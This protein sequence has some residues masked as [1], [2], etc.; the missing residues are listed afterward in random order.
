M[1]PWAKRVVLSVFAQVG[2][3]LGLG[4]SDAQADPYGV[5]PED[6]GA[7]RRTE[8]LVIEEGQRGF[9]VI[10]R[11]TLESQAARFVWLQPI[12]GALEA[13]DEA[14]DVFDVLAQALV[15]APEFSEELRRRPFGPSI[16]NYLTRRFRPD[17][18]RAE[19]LVAP[20]AR[21][22]EIDALAYFTGSAKTS[23]I[24]RRVSLPR[25]LED[26]L[27]IHNVSISQDERRF[28]G[29]YLNSGWSILGAAM[30]DRAPSPEGVAR[31]GPV[32]L[33]FSGGDRSLPLV[34]R[35]AP[36]A[37]ELVVYALADGPRVPAELPSRPPSRPFRPKEA[38]AG[39]ML[40]PH[41]DRLDQSPE[42]S[43]ALAE[44]FGNELLQD[45]YLT[46]LY[47][48]PGSARLGRLTLHSPEKVAVQ[49]QLPTSSQRGTPGDFF[50]CLLLG[51]TPLFLT[52]EAWLVM[53]VQAR[54]RDQARTGGSRLGVKL[55]A[56]WALFV[57]AYWFL[58]LHGL[59]RAAAIGPLL[60]G[61]FQL[62]LPFA[63]RDPLPVRAQF[64]RPKKEKV[65]GG[66]KSAPKTAQS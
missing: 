31:L 63:E 36:E 33:R 5:S 16:L 34:R 54:S 49:T 60:L 32:G 37:L 29:T 51:L 42:L 65:D 26:F 24:T 6:L 43:L 23:T 2:F 10:Q 4:L 18:G 12:F 13:V 48:R 59:A 8:A 55:W 50:T 66:S 56:V 46:Q 35:R 21:P 52:P 20:A 1:R 22:L 19:P 25:A 39:E 62:V 58:S 53:W 47:F 64:R 7:E 9:T 28:L 14:P 15:R 57:A 27:R 61:T 3:S 30:Y 41:A 40:V 45:A 44:P 17:P 38:P 11:L